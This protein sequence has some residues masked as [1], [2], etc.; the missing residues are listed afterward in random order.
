LDAVP[1][2]ALK[3]HRLSAGVVRVDYRALRRAWVERGH[4]VDE[5][6]AA[7]AKRLCGFIGRWYLEHVGAGGSGSS[8]QDDLVEDMI[9]DRVT[10]PRIL[11]M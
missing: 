2:T 10:P 11:P 6:P 1:F 9:D 7:D 8:E 3:L 5:L 4:A